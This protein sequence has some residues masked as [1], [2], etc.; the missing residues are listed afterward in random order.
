MS[1]LVLAAAACRVLAAAVVMVL[2]G[3]FSVSSGL[4]PADAL[5]QSPADG[6]CSV[7]LV[8]RSGESCVYPGTSDEFSVDGSGRGRF[9][10]FIEELG[11]N[12][13]NTTINGVLYNFSASR[14]SGGSW[15][16]E[17]AGDSTVS[18]AL[19]QE[20]HTVSSGFGYTCGLRT[21]GSAVC[22]GLGELGRT[23][24]PPPRVRNSRPSAQVTTG[25]A[26]FEGTGL[27]CAGVKM[28]RARR[29]RRP[30]SGSS[31]SAAGTATPAGFGPTAPSC[32]G[33]WLMGAKHLRPEVS[34]SH[35]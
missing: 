13:R 33:G 20:S 30:G 5:A 14:R 25:S 19:T 29:L 26:R 11:I 10:S 24:P 28:R 1:T 34:C 27:P 16:V 7:G 15:I 21:D 9:L 17:A 23:S 2:F 31:L 35:P 6:V 18:R 12:A 32:A 22:W 4:M 3:L 8:V